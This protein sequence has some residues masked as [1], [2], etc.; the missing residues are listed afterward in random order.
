MA[1]YRNIAGAEKLGLLFDVTDPGDGSY[2]SGN[3]FMLPQT[4]SNAD[5]PGII[6][7][8]SE[9]LIPKP[10]VFLTYPTTAVPLPSVPITYDPGFPIVEPTTVLPIDTLPK[11]TD[12]PTISVPLPD[13]GS[14]LP[15]TNQD[16]DY[17]PL[18]TMGALVF[19]A[20]YGEK[21]IP[22][23]RKLVFTAGIGLLYYQ[24]VR[25]E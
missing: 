17:M 10:S 18:L 15:V 1:L 3:T 24:F 23:R 22:K 12:T 2:G 16:I 11:L 9:T 6:P 8:P 5:T 13:G 4:E 7:A 25:K 21:L 20:I 19:T 14:A